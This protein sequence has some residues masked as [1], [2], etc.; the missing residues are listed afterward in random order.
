MPTELYD[1]SVPA[2]VR[3]LRALSAILDKAKAH[4]ESKGVDPDSWLALRVIEDMHPLS[5]QVQAVCDGPKLA[6]SRL[7]GVPA[8]KN[9]DTERTIDE[10][11]ARIASTVAWI[12]SVPRESVDG[13]E[14]R[15]IV[16][17]LPNGEMRFP[18]R[19][20]ITGFA[21]PNFYFHLTTAYVLLR[22]QGV[23]IGKRDFMGAAGR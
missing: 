12:E 19:V 4:A 9:D 7:S 16:L 2:F 1:L 11:D 18:G 22:G 8:P 14:A 20:Y 6:I 21:L 10:L 3:G 23:P 13:Q 15:E 5:R 17:P